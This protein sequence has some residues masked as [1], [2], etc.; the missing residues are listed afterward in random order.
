MREEI[1]DLDPQGIRKARLVY[2]DEG[3]LEYVYEHHLDHN[4]DAC[5]GTIWVSY[6]D[7]GMTG[8]KGEFWEVLKDQPDNL[9]LYPSINC[10][11]CTSHGWIQDGRWT[12]ARE[13]IGYKSRVM[14]NDSIPTWK[15]WFYVGTMRIRR[16]GAS[17]TGTG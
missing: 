14:N 7:Q 4:G 9:T 13:G 12:G 1:I 11:R 10:D 15:K 16:I 3:K 8:Y 17:L 5:G 6:E 2:D